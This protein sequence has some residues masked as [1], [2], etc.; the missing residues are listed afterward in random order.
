MIQDF[1][2]EQDNSGL[3]DLVVE[4]CQF[5]HVEGLETA[6]DFQLF[7]DRRSLRSDISVPIKRQ[8]W[9]GDLETKQAG[10]EAGSLLYLKYQSRDAVV[11]RQEAAKYSE[12]ALAYLV[13]IGAAERVDARSVGGIIEGTIDVRADEV[14]RYA[15]LWRVTD[16]AGS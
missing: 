9:I 16:A 4:D 2:V 13:A 10:Y 1:A 15:R 5:K 14:N 7:V 11:D 6:I 8:G 3:F 12:D